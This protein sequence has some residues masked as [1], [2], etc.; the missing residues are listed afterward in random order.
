[1]VS[2]RNLERKQKKV[3]ELGEIFK[4]NGVYL[5][6]YRGLAV[7]EMEDLR[8][9]IKTL[10]ANLKVIK[11]RMAIKYFENEEQ[12][13]GRE[14]F[15]GPIAIAYSDEKFVEVAKVIVDFEKESKKIKIKSGF[16]EKQF[17]DDRQIKDLARLPGRPQLMSQLAFS[18]AMPI[19][20]F[21]RALTAPIMN[22]L[23]LLNN[24]KDKKAKEE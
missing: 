20:K 2:Q 11:N 19:K 23:V 22:M 8:N 12:K 17:V 13:Y 16:I 1:M 4:N 3:D 24:L 7:N 5:F 14:V 6:D 9:K 15:R 18:M 21:G 10:N